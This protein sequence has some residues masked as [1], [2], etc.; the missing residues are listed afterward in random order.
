[1]HKETRTALLIS[2]G[3]L[4]GFLLVAILCYWRRKSIHAFF[5]KL[6]SGTSFRRSGDQEQN[7]SSETTRNYVNLNELLFDAEE[8][9][10]GRLT[11]TGGHDI[12]GLSFFWDVLENVLD[13]S[14]FTLNNNQDQEEPNN[15]TQDTNNLDE[16]LL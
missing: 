16:P 3:V 11:E 15:T 9:K 13:S 12:P 5:L 2:F 8:D 7:L 14:P 10:V 4:V 6:K 1:M